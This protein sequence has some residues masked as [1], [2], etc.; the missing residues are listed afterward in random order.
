MR[1][2]FAIALMITIL[3]SGF[4]VYQE[5]QAVC[6]APLAY[7]VGNVDERFLIT[8]DEIRMAL[9]DAESVWEQATGHNLFNYD[10]EADFVINFVFDDRQA[11]AEAEIDFRQRLDASEGVNSAIGETYEILTERY[12]TLEQEYKTKVASYEQRLDE[13]NDKVNDYN[14][15]GGAPQADYK[16]LEIERSKLDS[17]LETV[18]RLGQKLND[19][20]KQINTMSNK[21]NEL[22]DTYNQKVSQYNEQF[23]TSRE[24]TQGDYQGDEINIYKFVDGTE[25]RLVLAHELGHALSLGHVDGETSVMYD[26][27]G[28]QPDRLTLTE[29]DISE[30]ERICGQTTRSFIERLFIR[31]GL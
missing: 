17:E 11:F 18:N 24:F 15:D 19:L 30:F 20:V 28:A 12:Q 31:F 2:S 1:K 9:S 3:G 23:G 22:I 13:Y 8:E 14:Q 10:P 6:D 4:Y 7:R 27:L 5:V 26:H 21:G 16:K 29:A 25:L